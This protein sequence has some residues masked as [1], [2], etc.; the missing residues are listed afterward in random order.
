MYRDT[1]A[2]EDCPAPVLD[3]GLRPAVLLFF[4]Y[5]LHLHYTLSYLT[6]LYFRLAVYSNTQSGSLPCR[7]VSLCVLLSTPFF[8]TTV[9][10]SKKRRDTP[11]RLRQLE[12]ERQGVLF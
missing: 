5:L 6:L 12:P 2:M 9:R 10:A 8:V 4:V 1:A 11:S 3:L 7:T